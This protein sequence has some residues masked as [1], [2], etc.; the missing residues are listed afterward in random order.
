MTM[1]G[2]FH[3]KNTRATLYNNTLHSQT[4]ELAS[5]IEQHHFE[6]A[7]AFLYTLLLA[8]QLILRNFESSLQQLRLLLRVHGLQAG[9]NTSAW[10]TACVHDVLAVMVL[11]L[12]Q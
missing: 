1:L 6:I 11:G 8:L 2:C 9:C 4:M 5:R 3:T 12:V 10:V 7:H